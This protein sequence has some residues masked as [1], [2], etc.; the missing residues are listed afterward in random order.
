MLKHNIYKKSTFLSI[1]ID[2]FFYG[3]KQS[4]R[5]TGGQVYDIDLGENIDFS[6]L[7]T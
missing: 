4:I 6:A 5:T 1:F 7:H 2:T 3:K